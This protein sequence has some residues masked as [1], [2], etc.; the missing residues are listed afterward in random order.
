MDNEYFY[1]YIKYKNKYLLLKQLGGNGDNKQDTKLHGTLYSPAW[2]PSKSPPT[3]APYVLPLPMQLPLAPPPLA[4]PPPPPPASVLPPVPPPVL[5]IDRYQLLQHH[6][7]QQHISLV[8]ATPT[9]TGTATGTKIADEPLLEEDDAELHL[10]G[11]AE[12]PPK[13]WSPSKSPPTSAPYVLPLPMQ[14]PLAPPL[15]QHHRH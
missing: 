9:S 13:W 8:Q 4:P 11:Y 1:K 10:E 12:P 3:S 7:R 6:C 14:P 2:S 15:L 5:L